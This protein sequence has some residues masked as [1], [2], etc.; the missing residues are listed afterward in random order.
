MVE[1]GEPK[2]E[3]NRALRTKINNKF[4]K[5]ISANSSKL[6]KEKHIDDVEDLSTETI[7]IKIHR[8]IE[9]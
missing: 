1:T 9:I 6:N 4:L 7:Q 2:K 8:K 3:P 5:F